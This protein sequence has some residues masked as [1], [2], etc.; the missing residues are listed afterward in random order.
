MDI[1]IILLCKIDV[2][3][4]NA[5]IQARI[6]ATDYCAAYDGA[7]IEMAGEKFFYRSTRETSIV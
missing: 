2:N 3:A 1:K 4:G 7:F 5:E 6:R